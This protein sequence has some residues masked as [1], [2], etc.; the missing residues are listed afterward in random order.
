MQI[1]PANAQQAHTQRQRNVLQ[2]EPIEPHYRGPQGVVNES[3]SAEHQ[4]R[5]PD[6]E[7]GCYE[8]AEPP[9]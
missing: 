5:Q 9:P 7:R 2:P 1:Q 3:Q 8:A 4:P 6:D